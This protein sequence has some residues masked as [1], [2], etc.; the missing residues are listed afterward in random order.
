MKINLE[1]NFLDYTEIFSFVPNLRKT[2]KKITM[3][4]FILSPV[5]ESYTLTS[6]RHKFVFKAMIPKYAHSFW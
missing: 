2:P 5:I 3:L 4:P 1:S 6:V